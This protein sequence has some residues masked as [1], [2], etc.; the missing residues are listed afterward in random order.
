MAFGI[1]FKKFVSKKEYTPEEL[2]EAIKDHEFTPGKPMW[3]KHMFTNIICFPEVDR[4]NQVQLLPAFNAGGGKRGNKWN[5]QK[6][7]A[8]GGK[9]VAKNVALGIV[10]DGWANLG[11]L[12][13]KNSKLCE[14]Q[15]EEVLKELESMDI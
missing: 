5:L 13:G 2:Y 8:A 11:S 9:N 3:V 7:E 1:K 14:Q 10:S 12:G 4:Q 6:A 15:V